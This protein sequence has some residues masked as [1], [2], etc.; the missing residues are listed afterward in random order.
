MKITT[1]IFLILIGL[2][3][4]EFALCNNLSRSSIEET[5]FKEG[6][7]KNEANKINCNYYDFKY[8][9]DQLDNLYSE[10]IIKINE[11][12]NKK[13]FINAQ[14]AWLAYIVADCLSKN[15]APDNPEPSWHIEHYLCMSK[16]FND[17]INSLR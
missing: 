7:N 8:L 12:R 1:S 9:N 6:C 15:G 4:T 2:T 5:A 10:K 16:H 3:F 17:R 11:I 13:R 14:K